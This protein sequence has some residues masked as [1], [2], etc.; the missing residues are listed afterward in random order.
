[1]STCD[2]EEF[3]VRTIIYFILMTIAAASA[4]T[5]NNYIGVGVLCL[6]TSISLSAIEN[7]RGEKRG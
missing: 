3:A 6:I 1:M 7:L 5:T 4:Y 2:K